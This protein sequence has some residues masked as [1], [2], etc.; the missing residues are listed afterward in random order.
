MTWVSKLFRQR[1]NRNIGNQIIYIN[2]FRNNDLWAALVS[3]CVRIHIYAILVIR[4]LCLFIV[5]IRKCQRV[6][7]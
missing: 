1:L 3:I 4:L 7:I 6:K 2:V 5:R